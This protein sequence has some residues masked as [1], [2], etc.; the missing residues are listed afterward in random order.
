MQKFD[1]HVH[2]KYSDGKNTP[3]EMIRSA[4]AMGLE[5]IGLS[6]HA[7]TGCD[8]SCCMKREAQAAYQAEVR[9]LAEKYKDE[10]RVLCGVEQDYYS[11]DTPE[12]YDYVIGSVHYMMISGECVH[13]DYSAQML[14]N[15]ADKYFGGDLYCLCEIYYEMLAHVIEKTGGDI[16]GHFDLITKFNEN[17]AMFDETNPRYVAAWQKAADALLKTGKPFEINTGAIS[18]GYR[19]TPYPAPAIRRYLKDR[20]A[21]LFLSSDSHAE[22]TLANEFD[23]WQ[24]LLE[25]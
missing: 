13:V 4:I 19:V 10:I 20:G 1:L 17:G 7:Y 21:K 23:K 8:L 15:A 11:E 6:D 16:V 14:Q 5:T 24:S 18:R 22:N 9:A 25:E 3:E 12:G 2:S